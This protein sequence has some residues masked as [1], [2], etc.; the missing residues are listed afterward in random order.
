MKNILKGFFSVSAKEIGKEI[1][2]AA[3][4]AGVTYG[5]GVYISKKAKHDSRPG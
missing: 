2:L 3:I 1:A 5:I 4:A